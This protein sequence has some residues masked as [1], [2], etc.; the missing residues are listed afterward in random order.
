MPADFLT[1]FI[2]YCDTFEELP[3][4]MEKEVGYKVKPHMIWSINIIP[5]EI[6]RLKVTWTIPYYKR[7]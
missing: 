4:A 6:T 2:C 1:S 5:F 7:I 3:A